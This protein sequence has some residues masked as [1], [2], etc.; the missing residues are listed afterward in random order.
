[1]E[2]GP[3]FETINMQYL[4]NR[5][6]FSHKSETTSIL[7]P[8]SIHLVILSRNTNKLARHDF[9]FLKPCWVSEQNL[10]ANDNE[11]LL[12]ALTVGS[13]CRRAVAT[14][15][16]GSVCRRAAVAND[17][18]ADST[19]TKSTYH[20]NL[21]AMNLM[22]FDERDTCKYAQHWYLV[23]SV[24]S[25]CVCVCVCVCMRACMH[26]LMCGSRCFYTADCRLACIHFQSP[27]PDTSLCCETMNTGLVHR[28][29]WLLMPQLSLT[30]SYTGW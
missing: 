13:V 11:G 22:T 29:A 30:P 3:H 26:A 7:P 27:Q 23:H 15:T 24:S 14:S 1:M 10:S 18:E 4:S 2:D 12:L 9:P 8:S 21:M 5:G 17:N 25:L 28:V 6:L 19:T 20:V 16:L